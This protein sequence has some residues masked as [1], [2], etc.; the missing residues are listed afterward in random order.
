MASQTIRACLRRTGLAMLALVG[1]SMPALGQQVKVQV[2]GDYPQLQDNAEA[3]IG[4]VEGRSASNLRRYAS[5]AIS[6]VSEALQALGY[7]NPEISWKLEPG[8]ADAA[9]NQPRLLLTIVPGEPVRVKTR[10]SRY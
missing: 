5:T 9:D 10:Q 3:F 6:Q 4:D 7:Y 1:V 8:D 2:Q